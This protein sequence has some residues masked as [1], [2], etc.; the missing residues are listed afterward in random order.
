MDKPK[1][2]NCDSE[3]EALDKVLGSMGDDPRGS[4]AG[5]AFLGVLKLLP[6]VPRV[7]G[8]DI[9][10]ELMQKSV[11]VV[12]DLALIRP[13]K[14]VYLLPRDD[15][16]FGKGWHFPGGSRAPRTELVSDCERIAKRELG[17]D[18]HILSAK[19]T[20]F[21]DHPDSPRNHDVSFLLLCEFEGE[22]EGG[23][24][25]MEEPHDLIAYHH[26]YWPS[27]RPYL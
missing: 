5:E 9:F 6:P 24:W 14:G 10:V 15:E 8:A 22:P 23:K 26:S 19:I 17:A 7:P 20:R 12:I 13:R 11:S 4:F 2:K 27:I 25:F 21:E 16:Y 1:E 3:R 18:I